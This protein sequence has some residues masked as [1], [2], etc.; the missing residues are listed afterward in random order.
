VDVVP[1]WCDDEV[2][3][4]WAALLT[5]RLH[6]D[7]EHVTHGS[8]EAA[9]YVGLDQMRASLVDWY[10]PWAT[11]RLEVEKAIDLGDRVLMLTNAYGRMKGSDAEVRSRS[12]AVWT[13]RDGKI[14]SYDTYTHRDEAL[15]SRGAQVGDA[16]R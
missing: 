2:W 5:P 3:S 1:R 11:Y 16:L 10:E 4:E 13:I 15:E 12:A 14:A 7:F 8:I 9:R 6:S